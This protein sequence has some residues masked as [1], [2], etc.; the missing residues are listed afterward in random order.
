MEYKIKGDQAIANYIKEQFKILSEKNNTIDLC[1]DEKRGLD[2][3]A[4]IPL[5]IL[6][7]ICEY[8]VF[9]ISLCCNK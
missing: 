3:G 2:H 5:H 6:F 1:V 9:E 8:Q 7:P 4:Y